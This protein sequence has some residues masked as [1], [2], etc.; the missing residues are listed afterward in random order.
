METKQ[1][2]HTFYTF[3]LTLTAHA[4]LCNT[5]GKITPQTRPEHDLSYFLPRFPVQLSSL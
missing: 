1:E 3:C 4:D 2:L 5:K